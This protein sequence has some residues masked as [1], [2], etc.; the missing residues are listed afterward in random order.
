MKNNLFSINRAADI[1]QKD[2]QT[3]VRALR[4]TRPDGTERGQPRYLMPTILA[5]LDA[6]QGRTHGDANDLERQFAE[7][8][9]RYDAVRA[10]PAGLRR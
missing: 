2:R 9:A 4:H 8:E 6:H 1:L 10:A 7:L 5:A 3:L